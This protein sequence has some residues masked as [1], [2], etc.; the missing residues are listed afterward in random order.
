[1]I[2]RQ[3][4]FFVWWVLSTILGWIVITA[5]GVGAV[6][7]IVSTT[8]FFPHQV[9]YGSIYEAIGGFVIGLFQW[10]AIRHSVPSAWRWVV[11]SSLSWA[12]AVPVGSTIGMFLHRY[13]RLFL[14][15]VADLAIA[16]LVFAILTSIKAHINLWEV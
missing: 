9:V 2:L 11:I 5:I 3:R 6:G 12:I 4:I 14:G 13:T 8:E 15:E 10:L 1:M 7:W 16:C